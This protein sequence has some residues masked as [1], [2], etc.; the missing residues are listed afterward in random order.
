VGSDTWARLASRAIRVALAR[1]DVSY[2]ELAR[3]L[4]AEGVADSER[5][6]VSRVSRGTAEFSLLLRILQMAGATLP[7]LWT[8]DISRD[9]TWE[10]RAAA[11]LAAELAVQPWVTARELA[12]R[13][14]LI[15]VAISPR[16]VARH[17]S[18]GRFSLAFFLQCLT[19]LASHS[20]DQYVDFEDLR[21]AAMART[22]DAKGDPGPAFD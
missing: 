20:A 22:A 10:Q 7:P 4:A 6:L 13:L 9:G 16:T 2:A 19:V 5:A 15:G 18:T 11:V 1:K 21:L 8:A 12:R 17:V 14:S 3:A